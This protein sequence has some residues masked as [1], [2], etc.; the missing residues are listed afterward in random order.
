M[1]N[2][3]EI[4][5]IDMWRI[6]VR[7]WRWFIG[8]GL[9]V[10]AATF[11]YL[12]HARSQWEATAW[13]Q[14]GQVGSAPVGQDP[15]VEA[16]SRTVERLETRN[17]QDAVLD[18]VGVPVDGPAGR[19]YR[20]S[21]KI[22]QLAYA[23]I[24]KLRVRGYS[25]EDAKQLATATAT[26]LQDVHSRLGA[27]PLALARD[28][29]DALESELKEAEANRRHLATEATGKGDTAALA[30]IALA[31]NNA[32]IRG[33]EHARADLASRL[34]AN[35]TYETSTAWPVYAPK[36]RVFPNTLLTAGI[37]LL[38][39]AFLASL[40]A[41]ARHALRVRPVRAGVSVHAA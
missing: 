10:V 36:D 34:L 35:Y 39:A 29:L 6:V 22:E 16:F 4:Y 5:L 19:L 15:H 37:G 27:M 21:M 13:I 8:V 25:P 14:I 17:F 11:A 9:I 26:V 3:D 40:A 12:H 30:A 31:T 32:E 24:I 20:G 1:A 7:E 2:D 41:V 28:R 38:A 18:S 23:N 33:L